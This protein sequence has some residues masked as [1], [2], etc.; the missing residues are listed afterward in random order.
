LKESEYYYHG[1]SRDNCI[2]IMQS[3][4]ARISPTLGTLG[5][6]FYAF[7]YSCGNAFTYAIHQKRR[8]RYRSN[9]IAVLKFKLVKEY[10]QNNVLDL[11]DPEF[12][13]MYDRFIQENTSTI[14]KAISQNNLSNKG[15]AK[16][17]DGYIIDM[18]IDD[19]EQQ[20]FIDKV[21]GVYNITTNKLSKYIVPGTLVG[22]SAELSI[23]NNELIDYNSME[24]IE[25]DSYKMT[26]GRDVFS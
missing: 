25:Y 2:K 17:L 6:G 1:S 15:Y 4:S 24:L 12:L 7:A 3:K 11:T 16:K 23:K 18:F 14:K 9:K 10:E 26:R 19:L 8:N 13:E 20:D 21:M 22:N 5:C